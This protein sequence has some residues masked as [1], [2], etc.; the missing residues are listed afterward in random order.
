[1]VTIRWVLAFV[2]FNK[3]HICQL[4]IK[5]AFLHGKIDREKFINLPEGT[6]NNRNFVGKLNKA[7]Y[8]LVTA[9]RCWYLTFDEFIQN[10]GFQRNCREPCVYTKFENTN[11]LLILLYVDDMLLIMCCSSM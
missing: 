9:P 10:N 4:D 6:S 1:M 11:V 5:T 2:S 7:L 3:W 8:G